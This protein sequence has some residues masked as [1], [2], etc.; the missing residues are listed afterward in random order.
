MFNDKLIFMSNKLLKYL[1]SRWINSENNPVLFLGTVQSSAGWSV[2][3]IF[4]SI[5]LLWSCENECVQDEAE[6]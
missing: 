1:D 2:A 4:L 3:E 5:E 6:D